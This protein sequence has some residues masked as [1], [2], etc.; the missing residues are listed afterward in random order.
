VRTASRGGSGANGRG[1]RLL[2]HDAAGA[3]G[4]PRATATRI[5]RATTVTPP[6][7]PFR[8]PRKSGRGFA[9]KH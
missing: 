9:E 1:W 3:E 8:S 2:H 5:A 7:T 6:P 4:E